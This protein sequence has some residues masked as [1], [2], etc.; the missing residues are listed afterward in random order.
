MITKEILKQI[1][2]Y[3]NDKIITDL[4]EYF[5]AYLPEYEVNSYLRVCHFLAQCAHESDSFKTLQEYASGA[6]YEGRKDL[7]NTQPGDGKRYKGR[8]IIQLTGR[9]NY[10]E[11]GKALG[12]DLEGNPE[13][14]MDPETSVRTA[15]EYWKRK[16]LNAYADK[17][18]IVTITKR[19][20]GG[21][22][23]LE[24]RKN[25]LARAKKVLKDFDFS[26]LE[27]DVVILAQRG[28]NS[29]YVATI[30]D[31]LNTKGHSITV[32]GNF[33]PATERAVREFQTSEGLP[34]TGKVDEE[35]M[36]RLMA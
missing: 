15:L 33:G 32:D 36:N 29:D 30:Q 12:I 19:I 26:S 3:A 27:S 35:T 31:L 14:A 24:D 22:N 6:A 28:E 11:Y 8:G 18:D 1:A 34:V 7:G 23:G 10:R 21:T 25:Y 13:L 2:P 16:G 4:E 20:N 5:D 17:D 9:A